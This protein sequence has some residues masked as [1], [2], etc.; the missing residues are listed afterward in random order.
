M[1]ENQSKRWLVLLTNPENYKVEVIADYYYS[2]IL[3]E[4]PCGLAKIA[5]F[6]KSY[7]QNNILVVSEIPIFYEFK[8]TTM[9]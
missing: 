6:A 7:G 2:N 4:S 9:Y 1:S 5:N 3:P 8:A